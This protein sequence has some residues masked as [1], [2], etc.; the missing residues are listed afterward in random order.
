MARMSF[1]CLAWGSL[2]WRPGDLPIEGDWQKDGQVL[3]LE[4]ARISNS[5]RITLVITES[6][7]LSPTFWGVM[8]VP[9]M[10]EAV[11]ALAQ[12]EEV[13]RLSA[14]GRVP[15]DGTHYP[16]ADAIAAWAA[17]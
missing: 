12:R 1:A 11:S 2:W 8:A 4:F 14:I 7:S 3:P 13:E 16:F 10:K 6:G 15:F 17:G 9:T 5:G